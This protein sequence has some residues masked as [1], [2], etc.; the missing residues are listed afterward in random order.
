[1]R[2]LVV[3]L[4]SMLIG[5]ASAQY[6]KLIDE[7]KQWAIKYVYT[8]L[9]QIPP[10]TVTYYFASFNGDTIIN[11]T[12]YK[13]L[14]HQQ[15]YHEEWYTTG[16]PIINDTLQQ[17]SLV[18]FIRED[19][20]TRM[21]Y[22]IAN[23]FTF[24]QEDLLFDYSLNV[25]DTLKNLFTSN[26]GY[27]NGE[28]D[29]ITEVILNNGDTNRVLHFDYNFIPVGGLVLNFMIE[30][31]GGP[32][33]LYNPFY[34]LGLSG[35]QEETTIVC[36]KKSG[37]DLFGTCSYPNFFTG[38]KE[39]KNSNAVSIHPNPTQDRITIYLEETLHN[40]KVSIR[41]ALGQLVFSE[42]MS[43]TELNINLNTPKGI[44][45]LQLEVDG[46]FITKKIIK[47]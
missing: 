35:V 1:M 6:K 16:S 21:V 5:S 3:I 11:S 36:Y 27:G 45:F 31:V 47:Q 28:I 12:T 38:V 9:L 4:L 14:Y 26:F 40:S 20:T 17:S 33:G 30:G 42:K 18:A 22:Q 23:N 34:Y 32:G 13:R 19:T 10:P 7:N 43:G 8:D 29:S 41:N 37:V 25:G 39:I 24:P 15:F 44:Y 46:K 2:F